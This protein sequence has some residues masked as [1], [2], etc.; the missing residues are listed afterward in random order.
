MTPTPITL[1]ENNMGSTGMSRYPWDLD[2]MEAIGG[3][4]H[5][6]VGKRNSTPANISTM[7][8]LFQGKLTLSQH[9]QLSSQNQNINGMSSSG[10]HSGNV[11][12]HRALDRC[13]SEP[14]K[15]VQP[16]TSSSRYK[17]ELCRPY[18]ETGFCKYGEKCQF[19]HGSS[20]LR[21]MPRHPKYKTELC[22]T[23]HT[24]GLCGY[25]TRCHFIHNADERRLAV[26]NFANLTRVPDE[27]ASLNSITPPGSLHG[28]PTTSAG[29]FFGD[30]FSILSNLGPG[31]DGKFP[32]LGLDTPPVSPVESLAG[33]IESLSLSSPALSDSPS[34]PLAP[35]SHQSALSAI[36]D[37][38][39]YLR[40]PIFET[41]KEL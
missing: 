11:N 4:I 41:L 23:F 33:D 18:A 26:I 21:N 6:G 35:Q 40:L 28:S 8:N 38:A 9:S 36:M 30:S 16:V 14:L 2:Q 29:T 3:H 24:T 32:L 34:P 37:N 7:G 10:E 22:R 27:D 19:A 17:T 15:Q 20:E 5:V 1:I 12:S 31:D 39:R 13:H 25:G